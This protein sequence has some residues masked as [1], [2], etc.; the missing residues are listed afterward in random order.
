MSDILKVLGRN[1]KYYRTKLGLTQEELA[2]LSGVNRSHL[3]G[4]ESAHLNPAVKTI[5]KLARG[6]E[7]SV[8]DLFS[9]NIED[10]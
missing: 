10:E 3:A 1:I 6:L 4:I 5:E 8:S 2:K 7:V 9:T